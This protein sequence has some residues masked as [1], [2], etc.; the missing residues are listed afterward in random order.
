MN[1]NEKNYYFF[2]GTEAELIKLLPVLKEFEKRNIPY[3]IIASGQ[4]NIIQSNILQLLKNKKIEIILFTGDIKQTVSG[5]F[6]WF[7]KTLPK[8]IFQLKNEFRKEKRNDTFMIIHGDTVST[9]MGALIAKWL[10]LQLAHIEA[11]LRSFN[12]FHPFPEELD[13]VIASQFGRIHF[14]PNQWAV[15]NLKKKN[16]VKINTFQNTLIESFHLVKELKTKSVLLDNLEKEKFFIFIMH[17][18]ENL[19][20]DKLVNLLINEI[21]NNAKKMKCVFVIH[22]PTML[23]LEKKQLLQGLRENKNIILCERLDYIEFMQLLQ[24]CEYLI[25]DGGSNQEE[26]YYMGKPALILRSATERIEGLNGNVLLS[27][28]DLQLIRTFLRNPNKYK[29]NPVAMKI[30]PSKIITDYLLKEAF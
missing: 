23:V 19:F 27:R 24:K 21:T 1:P 14:C 12:Y 18:Q 5:L 15:D 10:G 16:G 28:N 8:A 2:I 7:I 11:G 13:R 25:T 9:V 6:F 3:K 26:A 22:K 17:R 30:K 20:N 4:N 29:R